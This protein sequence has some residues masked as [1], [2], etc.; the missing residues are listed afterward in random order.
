MAGNKK[1]KSELEALKAEMTTLSEAVW[2]L[3]ERLTIQAAT[4]AARDS[5]GT[6]SRRAPDTD[7]DGRAERT[8]GGDEPGFVSTY[9]YYEAGN[10][11]YRWEQEEQSVD[12]LLAVD[13][14]RAAHL[15][16]ALGHR[17]R[18]AILLAILERPCSAAELVE[19]LGLGTTGAAYHHL[20]V[21]QAADIVVQES[22]GVFSFHGHRVPGFLTLLAGVAGMLDI[23]FSAGPFALT[24]HDGPAVDAEG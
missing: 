17:Q 2:A 20:N 5:P 22:R 10:R 1:K 15:L 9:G 4:D 16:S 19:R 23:E 6:M 11:G 3:R 12:A 18:L 24:A 7:V 21:L 14:E 8:R 13:D